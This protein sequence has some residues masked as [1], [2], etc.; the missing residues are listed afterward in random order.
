MA[1]TIFFRILQFPLILAVIYLTTFLLAW[2]APGSPFD[3][4]GGKKLD[5]LALAQL[6]EQFH[7]NSTWAFLTYYPEQII[8]HQDFGPSMAQR[9]WS[10]NDI[11]KSSLPVSIT[12]GLFALTIAT[13]VGVAV[14]TLSAVRRGGL[15]DWLG[16][17]LTLIGI[18]LPSFVSA[19]VLLIIFSGEL[20][21]F[22]VGGWGGFDDMILPAIAL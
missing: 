16:L 5:P 10:V 1:K 22:P 6:Q 3:N 14:G 9:G 21:W 7:A 11:L 2:V 20:K 18:S 17:S 19:A 8:L 4:P 12:L 15:T 13:F